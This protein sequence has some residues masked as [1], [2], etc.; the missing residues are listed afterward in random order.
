[1]QRHVK[2][3]KKKTKEEKER[4]P[5]GGTDKE[6]LYIYFFPMT[7]KKN[8]ERGTYR[9]SHTRKVKFVELIFLKT[10]NGVI[11]KEGSHQ[12]REGKERKCEGEC[13]VFVSHL[14]PPHVRVGFI[15]SS[16]SSNQFS[17]ILVIQS[18]TAMYFCVH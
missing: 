12:K 2:L 4:K 10:K 16:S 14:A 11:K 15:T 5:G 1:M 13:F 3:K 17:P 8:I 9:V 7:R 6:H 18:T